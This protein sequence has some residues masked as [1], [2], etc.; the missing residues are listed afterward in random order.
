MTVGERAWI[1]VPPALGF[2]DKELEAHGKVIPANSH[3]VFDVMLLGVSDKPKHERDFDD[4]D[5]Q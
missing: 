3:L 1:L 2:G 4:E 5:E